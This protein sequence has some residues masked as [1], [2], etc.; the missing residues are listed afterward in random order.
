[1][2]CGDIPWNFGLR[3]RPDNMVGTSGLGS[4]N[5]HWYR[6]N[7]KMGKL[8]F[9]FFRDHFVHETIRRFPVKMGL[10]PKSSKSLHLSSIE[11]Y[12]DLGDPSFKW[13]QFPEV[14]PSDF[15]SHLKDNPSEH[16][17]YA[18]YLDFSILH[19]L[20][21]G[22]EHF[23]FSHNIWDNHPNWPIFFKMVKT[24]NQES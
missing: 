13:V 2:N 21:G 18:P 14:L 17:R 1:M 4:W 9:F 19:I 3:N 12:S 22:L 16:T 15:P 11:T 20:V 6:A 23:L 10:P 24:T 8:V 5:G 7:V